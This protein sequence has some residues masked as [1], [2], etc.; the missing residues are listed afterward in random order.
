MLTDTMTTVRERILKLFPERQFIHRTGGQVNYFMLTTRTQLI[1]ST[2]V[3]IVLMW[4][5]FTFATFLWGQSPM[6]AGA[7]KLR[8]Q[9]QEFN[10]HLVNLDAKVSDA[11]EL[12][13]RQQAEFKLAAESFEQKHN[14]IVTMLTQGG[15]AIDE[16]ELDTLMYARSDVLMSPVVLDVVARQPRRAFGQRSTLQTGT[17]LDASM[18]RLEAD[19]NEIL[20]EGEAKIQ[21]RIERNRAILRAT[22]LPLS[23][24]LKNGSYGVG[25]PF[26]SLNEN[27]DMAENQGKVK[28]GAFLPHL[29]SIKA[30]AAEVESLDKALASVPLAHPIDAE[31]YLTSPYGRR[32]DPFTKRPTMHTGIDMA[33]YRLAPIVATADGKVSFVGRRSGYG[34]VVEIDH[35]HGFKTR[36]AHLAKTNVKRGQSVEKGE[37][38]AGMGSSGR[39]TSTHLHYEIFFEKNRQNPATFLKAGQYVQ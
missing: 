30:R 14:T 9:K 2:V 17:I 23:D 22:G 32:K 4:S 7:R 3:G 15:I 20:V 19:Q 5:T 1:I 27:G 21:T 38:I 35:G 16:T 6:E 29:E 39:S 31:S 12:L 28:T 8:V 37:K 11:K 10:R 36:Y 13:G 33:S 34:R 25:G 26:V 18:V 24:I